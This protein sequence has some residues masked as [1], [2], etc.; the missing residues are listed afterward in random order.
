MHEREIVA[1]LMSPALPRSV[2]QAVEG[3]YDSSDAA[4]L[5]KCYDQLTWMH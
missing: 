3:Y 1:W 2:E 5:A 4:R